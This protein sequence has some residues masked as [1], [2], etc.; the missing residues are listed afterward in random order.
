MREELGQ[1]EQRHAGE[2]AR[3][4]QEQHAELGVIEERIKMAMAKKQEVI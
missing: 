1:L 4:K 3:V 2:L